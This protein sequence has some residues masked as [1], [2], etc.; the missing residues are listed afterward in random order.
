MSQPVDSRGAAGALPGEASTPLRDASL[1]DVSPEAIAA[2]VAVGAQALHE[3]PDASPTR[4]DALSLLV[5][6]THDLRSPLS[7]MLVLIEQ[8]RSGQSG[9]LTPVQEKQLGL[10]Y[11]AAFGVASLTNDALDTARRGA[12]DPTRT[13]AAPFSLAVVWRE[14]RALVQPIAEEK[15]L[16]LRWSGP[17]DDTRV[18]HAAALQRVLLNLVTNALK[19]TDSGSVTVSAHCLGNGQV[20]ILVADTGCGL[21]PAVRW[22]LQQAAEREFVPP[23]SSAGLGLSTCQQLLMSMGSRL[24]DGTEPG[25]LGTRL[26]FVLSLPPVWFSEPSRCSLSGAGVVP[27]A[28]QRDRSHPFPNDRPTPATSSPPN[29]LDMHDGRAG[30]RSCAPILTNGPRGDSPSVPPTSGR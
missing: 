16:A 11:A 18:G 28:S 21:P 6:I 10:L 27:P 19:F 4:P 12:R 25:H 22:Q 3:V 1:V 13:P 20:R 7:S 29:A 8:L 2:L 30:S 23:A 5:G 24:E 26:G 15:Q 17:R 9:P 14:V